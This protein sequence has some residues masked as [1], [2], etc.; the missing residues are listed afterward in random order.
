MAT[1]Q[2]HIGRFTEL[3]SFVRPT[4]KLTSTGER[5]PAYVDCGVR[6]GEVDED[7]RADELAAEALAEGQTL[8]FKCWEVREASTEWRVR[9]RGM[10]F[11]VVK[12]VPQQRFHVV[13]YYLKR[14]DLCN[15]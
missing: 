1:R 14:I 2:Y 4:W 15:A 12:V 3:A 6:Y 10:L 8:C 7:V 13:F 11:Q 5:E 9:L